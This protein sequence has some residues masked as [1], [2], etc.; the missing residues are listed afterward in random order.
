MMDIQ[1]SSQPVAAEVSSEHLDHLVTQIEDELHSSQVYSL[2]LMNL[3]KLLGHAAVKGDILIRAVGREAIQIALK[4]MALGYASFAQNPQLQ[5]I[6]SVASVS[7]TE[8]LPE[9][10]NTDTAETTQTEIENTDTVENIDTAETT[11]TEIENTDTVENTDTEIENTDTVVSP[12]GYIAGGNEP[13]HIKSTPPTATVKTEIPPETVDSTPGNKKKKLSKADIA[14]QKVQQRRDYLRQIAQ[15]FQQARQTLGLSQCELHRSTMVPLSH[16]EALEMAQEDQLP[17]DVYL[18]GFICRLGNALGLDGTALAAALPAPD[19]LQ[20]ITPSWSSPEPDTEFYLNQFHLYLGYAALLAGS[21]GGIALLSQQG[22][23]ENVPAPNVPD[24]PA[25]NSSY[26]DRS[27]EPEL[28]PG[29]QQ[30]RDQ[31]IVVGVDIV[32]PEIIR[33]QSM[34]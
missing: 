14:A 16:L 24:I 30:S 32:R 31:G 23:P 21:I 22:V 3:Q 1:P 8:E 2:S 7:K 27:I 20:S 4:Q 29:L 19:P 34:T 15:Q 12:S 18:R 26:L 28:T 13:H 11:Q 5:T 33:S 9:A 10:E 25:N 17:E 6:P